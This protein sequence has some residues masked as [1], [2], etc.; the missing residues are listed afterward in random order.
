[1]S[2][3]QSELQN[4]TCLKKR[5]HQ[6]SSVKNEGIP[7]HAQELTLNLFTRSSPCL[8][9][10]VCT[11]AHIH[12]EVEHVQASANVCR[13]QI[14]VWASLEL[15]LQVIVSLPTWVVRT[16][17]WYCESGMNSKPLSHLS[18]PLYIFLGE[19]AKLDEVTQ[20]S[21]TAYS[22]YANSSAGC[23]QSLFLCL[24]CWVD[25][26]KTRCLRIHVAFIQHSPSRL[27]TQI[28][29]LMKI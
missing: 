13:V 29:L 12:A 19:C 14:G 7:S 16:K 9:V 22:N 1:M 24:R 10:Y 11:Y 3:D 4:E 15:Q 20:V 8:I 21:Q 18:M 25:K 2:S 5:E 17:P 6:P 27:L 28:G 23:I 26:Q